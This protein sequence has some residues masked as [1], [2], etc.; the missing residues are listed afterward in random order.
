[1]KL[2]LMLQLHKHLLCLRQYN[3]TDSNCSSLIQ[4]TSRAHAK[5]DMGRKAIKF[6]LQLNE[7]EVKMEI[8]SP[9]SLIAQNTNFNL[10]AIRKIPLRL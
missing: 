4:K 7:L 2:I 8:I 3:V 1:M 10:S 9:H 5:T 6:Y